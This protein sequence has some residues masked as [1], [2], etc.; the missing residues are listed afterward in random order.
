MSNSLIIHPQAIRVKEV[1]MYKYIV[2]LISMLCLVACAP[3]YE[4]L[5]EKRTKI[6]TELVLWANCRSSFAQTS[7][8]IQKIRELDKI[9]AEI[10]KHYPAKCQQELE[11]NK[12]KVVK[13]YDSFIIT[14]DG[15]VIEADKRTYFYEGY[16]Y[17]RR[18][19]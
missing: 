5:C 12:P 14:S 7:N 9:T 11:E 13:T 3:S 19:S 18:C 16:E 4:E 17:G 15:Y 2:L 10:E 1:S 6:E 8:M